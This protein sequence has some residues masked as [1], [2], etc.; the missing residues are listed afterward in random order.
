MPFAQRVPV[1]LVSSLFVLS[2]ACMAAAIVHSTHGLF[3]YPLDDSYIHLALARTLAASGTWGLYPGEF[4]SA[5]SS[6]G[7]TVLLAAIATVTGT[8]LITPLLLNLLFGI[9]LCF[10]L[11]YGLRL[12]R[13]RSSPLFRALGLLLIVFAAPITNLAFIGMEHVAQTLSML[14]LLLFAAQVLVVP[15]G[16][17]ITPRLSFVLCAAAFFAGALR[18][19]AVFG[20]LPII[21]LLLVRRRLLLAM[22]VSTA[23]AL[24]PVAFGLFSYR[25][26]GMW[27]P[28]SVMMKASVNRP[29]G[30]SWL[31]H[32]W[33]QTAGGTF[34]PALL[35]PLVLLAFRWRPQRGLWSLSQLLLVLSSIVTALHLAFAPTRWLMRYD[36][37]FIALFLFSSLAAMP[38]LG[39]S[40]ALRGRFFALPRDRQILLSLAAILT[41]AVTPFLGYRIAV[42]VVR[43]PMASFDRYNEHIQMAWFVARFFD[44][45]AVVAN[46]VGAVA[47]YSQSHLLDAAGLASELPSKL[48]HEGRPMTA[49]DLAAWAAAQRAPVAILQTDWGYIQR[50][51][52]PGWIA[53][54]QWKLAR[55]IVFADRTV[56]FYATE[57][58]ALPRICRSLHSFTLPAGV[59]FVP[60]PGSC[61]AEPAR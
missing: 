59:A 44:H 19:E 6:P 24:V 37:Y 31:S 2:L 38:F 16:Q 53:V 54:G 4:A 29:S 55:N 40:R 34:R 58:S 15:W 33:E 36:A 39:E 52:P 14:L 17:P 3:V 12:V 1:L 61:P 23:A 10:A 42:G 21:V 18:Y 46:D 56:G 47:F 13:P 51:L 27:L 60:S 22:L 25:H 49:A 50:L 45:D 32:L 11:D 26:S 35:L 5:S 20:I 41:L 57:P 9:A 43:G 7:W 28:F 8:H 30:G 48:L